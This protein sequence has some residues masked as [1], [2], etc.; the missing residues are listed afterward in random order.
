LGGRIWL[1]LNIPGERLK[2]LPIFL[3]DRDSDM[4]RLAGFDV[5][6]G[7]RLAG[8]CAANDTTKLAVL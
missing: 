2:P 1:N 4:T 3:F 5:V 6:N 8:V 7:S